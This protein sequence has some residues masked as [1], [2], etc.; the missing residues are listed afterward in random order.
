MQLVVLS[1]RPAMLRGT[2]AHWRAK[3]PWVDEVLVVTP[4][5]VEDLPCVLDVELL[6]GPGPGDHSTR[7]YAL[8]AALATCDAVADVFL[9]AD[10]DNR[11]LVEVPRE[12]FVRDGRYRRYAF[13]SLDDWDARAT[14]FD[15]CL[16]ASR[17]VLALHG[18]P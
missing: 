9:M 13:A 10:D 17:Q 1:A 11:P 5:P 2:L 16:L 14:S 12:A 18:L 6:D 8:R 15:A 3:V 4:S 7:N